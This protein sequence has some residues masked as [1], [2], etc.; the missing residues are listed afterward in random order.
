LVLS[1]PCGRF[2]AIRAER[3]CEA[4]SIGNLTIGVNKGAGSFI[5]A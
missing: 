1:A 4:S 5:V 3:W 2:F